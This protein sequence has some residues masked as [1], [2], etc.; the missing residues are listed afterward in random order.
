MLNTHICYQVS[1][2]TKLTICIQ[3]CQI[4]YRGKL[5]CVSQERQAHAVSEQQD[6]DQFDLFCS[7]RLSLAEFIR[8]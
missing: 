2:N 7:A 6:V 5:K 3:I 1:T 4:T 8:H